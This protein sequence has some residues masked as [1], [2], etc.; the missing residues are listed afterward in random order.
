MTPAE[1]P[2]INTLEQITEICSKFRIPDS[3]IEE[4]RTFA[5]RL[6]RIPVLKLMDSF[7]K[8]RDDQIR[9]Y[10]LN[11]PFIYYDRIHKHLAT[12][13]NHDHIKDYNRFV[14]HTNRF[15]SSLRNFLDEQVETYTKH[16]LDYYNSEESTSFFPG[17]LR[18]VLYKFFNKVVYIGTRR[19]KW[20]I[21]PKPS[22]CVSAFSMEVCF[23]PFEE[24][25]NGFCTL[26]DTICDLM[27]KSRP[28]S[29]VINLQDIFYYDPN[30]NTTIV[31]ENG[32]EIFHILKYVPLKDVY[33]ECERLVNEIGYGILV[34][35]YSVIVPSGEAERFFIHIRDY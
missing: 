25:Y 19:T 21:K 16:L 20:E 28:I 9:S 4:I 12:A 30:P 22:W 31:D 27:S 34:D 33:A 32:N 6:G 13:Y 17:F 35:N 1:F 15:S 2:Y 14:Y 8:S 29:S 26:Y 23:L 24:A 11:H 5:F 10:V 7:I 18:W 3:S